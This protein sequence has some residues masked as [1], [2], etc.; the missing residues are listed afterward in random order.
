M[1]SSFS[2][3]FFDFDYTLADSSRGA[4]KCIN[5]ALTNLGFPAVTEEEACK[6]IGLSLPDTLTL[7]AGKKLPGHVFLF[8]GWTLNLYGMI[9]F[10]AG[11]K[12]L[13]KNL[14]YSCLPE[15]HS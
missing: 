3:I 13:G 2:T 5:F 8:S 4:V 6:T 12:A 15:G 1:N 9:V 14:S 10:F 11:Y 7:L